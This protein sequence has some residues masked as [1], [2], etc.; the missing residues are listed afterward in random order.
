MGRFSNPD[1]RREIAALHRITRQAGRPPHAESET[2]EDFSV[3]L[4]EVIPTTPAP[5]ATRRCV[6]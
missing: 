2:F 5:E 6:G 3:K 1:L 4:E